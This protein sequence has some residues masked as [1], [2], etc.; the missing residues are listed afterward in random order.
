MSPQ[1]LRCIGE[2]L[3]GRWGWQT[4]IAQALR[5]DG[6]TVRRWIAGTTAI[7]G[8]AAVALELL[9]KEYERQLGKE[10]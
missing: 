5:V 6:S 7:P 9:L 8:P 10:Q 4:K 1:E 2:T 3:Y